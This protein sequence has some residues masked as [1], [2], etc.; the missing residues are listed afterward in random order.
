MTESWSNHQTFLRD[1]ITSGQ[2][3]EITGHPKVMFW[4]CQTAPILKEFEHFPTMAISDWVQVY[5]WGATGWFTYP[6]V[7]SLARATKFR[8]LQK[9]CNLNFIKIIIFVRNFTGLLGKWRTEFTSSKLLDTVLF[10]G[11]PSVLLLRYFL[12]CLRFIYE[13]AC[14]GSLS[15]SVVNFARRLSNNTSGISYYNCVSFHP[16]LFSEHLLYLIYSFWGYWSLFV[17]TGGCHFNKTFECLSILVWW[18]IVLGRTIQWS[19]SLV[20]ERCFVVKK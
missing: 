16:F 12:F 19:W 7:V 1:S 3:G 10:T 11:W 17:A 4:Y 6:K 20:N 5:Y 8:V 15:S 14:F 18:Y 13:I 9:F 2:L